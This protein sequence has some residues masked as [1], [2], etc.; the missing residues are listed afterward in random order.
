[1]VSESGKNTAK[2]DSVEEI[3]DCRRKKFY[4]D[5]AKLGR[6]ICSNCP[7]KDKQSLTFSKLISSVPDKMYETK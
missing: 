6:E 3:T 1:M 5:P 2:F 4:I 7:E